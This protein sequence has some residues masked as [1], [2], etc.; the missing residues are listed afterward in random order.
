ML[1]DNNFWVSEDVKGGLYI[2]CYD[3]MLTVKVGQTL[4]SIRNRALQINQ[5]ANNHFILQFY[6]PFSV[7]FSDKEENEIFALAME[8]LLHD[9]MTSFCNGKPLHKYRGE[10]HYEC[11]P[12]GCE[13][14][15]ATFEEKYPKF[16]KTFARKEK[17][18]K[19]VFVKHWKTV[20]KYSRR[21]ALVYLLRQLNEPE[22]TSKKINY[23][24]G[25]D[26][27]MGCLAKFNLSAE[28]L[29]KKSKLKIWLFA[30]DIG[31]EELFFRAIEEVKANNG[32]TYMEKKR[33]FELL[34]ED[35]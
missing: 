24:S 18:L 26:V 22:M 4:G 32:T 13:T 35:E 15:F 33:F 9:Y 8:D 11:T 19:Q 3:D 7:S 1:K 31:K 17:K 29:R 10:D 6:Y 34:E 21:D 27:R 23:K 12:T 16:M 28:E 14:F 30:S 25:N 2:G 20:R 5:N